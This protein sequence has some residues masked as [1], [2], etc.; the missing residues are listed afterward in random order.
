MNRQRLGIRLS[1]S[2]IDTPLLHHFSLCVCWSLL[3]DVLYCLVFSPSIC[4][5]FQVEATI[6]HLTHL[7]D[8]LKTA[9]HAKL[10]QAVDIASQVRW[11]H[12]PI[13]D[14]SSLRGFN[15]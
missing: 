9:Q 8:M 10:L 5:Y 15:S 2:E 3:T 4:V 7:C 14:F 6:A 11:C 12:H 13:R 1:G